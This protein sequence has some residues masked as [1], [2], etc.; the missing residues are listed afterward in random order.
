MRGTRTGSQHRHAR[1]G[2]V[3]VGD[4]ARNSLFLGQGTEVK[5]LSD[6]QRNIFKNNVE[7]NRCHDGG[8]N[9]VAHEIIG[10]DT[11]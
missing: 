4:V 9:S 11:G 7:I 3:R 1:Q 8:D 10:R 5:R 6:D 2:Q